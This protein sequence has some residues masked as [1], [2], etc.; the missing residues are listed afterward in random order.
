MSSTK[1]MLTKKKM[2]VG[3]FSIG[4]GRPLEDSGEQFSEV[5]RQGRTRKRRWIAGPSQTIR[6]IRQVSGR[7]RA[8]ETRLKKQ[9][10]AEAGMAW[11]WSFFHT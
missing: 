11:R 6:T 2:D 9:S 4:L 8:S 7:N 10:G 3:P 1:I 5:R